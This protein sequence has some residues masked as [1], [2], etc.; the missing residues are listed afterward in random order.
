M[1]KIITLF[2]SLVML[3]S[4][5]GCSQKQTEKTIQNITLSLNVEDQNETSNVDVYVDSKKIDTIENNSQGTYQLEL[6]QGSHQLK[7]R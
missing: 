7:T 3:F 2:L 4:F 5:S 1:K 6:V